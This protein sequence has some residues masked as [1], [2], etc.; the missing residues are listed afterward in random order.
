MAL[1][2]G[3]MVAG[4]GGKITWSTAGGDGSTNRID[5]SKW[6]LVQVFNNA[7][8]TNSGCGGVKTRRRV[9][10][11]WTFVAEGPLQIGQTYAGMQNAASIVIDFWQPNGYRYKGQCLLDTL[12]II[13]D[14]TGVDVVRFVMTGSCASAL[15]IQNDIGVA[16]EAVQT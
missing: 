16:I 3:N 11:D 9:S 12:T 14:S 15:T 2:G 10:E 1:N 5:V 6:T 13:D 8:C 7:D 4:I